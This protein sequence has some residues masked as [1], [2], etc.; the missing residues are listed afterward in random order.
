MFEQ[1]IEANLESR[2]QKSLKYEK[3]SKTLFRLRMVVR[4]SKKIKKEVATHFGEM[5]HLPFSHILH[6]LARNRKLKLH[7][8]CLWLNSLFGFP[9]HYCIKPLWV[10]SQNGG[11]GRRTKL[12]GVLRSVN[13]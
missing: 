5:L 13:E 7:A 8:P 4:M 3:K 10:G 11:W 1:Y 6:N 9:S 2:Q 12:G